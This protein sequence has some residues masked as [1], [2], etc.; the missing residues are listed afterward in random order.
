[1]SAAQSA[2][3]VELKGCDTISLQKTMFP[4]WQCIAAMVQFGCKMGVKVRWCLF[5]AA[6]NTE[7]SKK[8]GN[9]V[10]VELPDC[11]V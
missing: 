1:M 5:F 11:H 7:T 8:E 2:A 3:Q 6:H 4:P 9:N 10:T